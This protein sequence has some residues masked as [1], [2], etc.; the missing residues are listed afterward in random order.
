MYYSGVERCKIII[1]YWDGDFM[2]RCLN[3]L[4][5][6][7]VMTVAMMGMAFAQ[8]DDDSKGQNAEK[9][10]LYKDHIYWIDQ[11]TEK[12]YVSKV[13]ESEM[14]VFADV[15]RCDGKMA[16]KDGYIYYYSFSR[17]AIVK[18]A[19]VGK[20]ESEIRFDGELIEDF[21]ISDEKVYFL[22][23]TYIEDEDREE[24]YICSMGLNGEGMKRLTKGNSRDLTLSKGVIYFSDKD[25]CG[26]IY[27]YDIADGTV[28]KISEEC[29]DKI[30]ID[31]GKLY[32]SNEKGLSVMNI[33]GSECNFLLKGGYYE[34][35]KVFKENI[36]AI[37]SYEIERI[38]S[39]G[40][41]S[42]YM[43]EDGQI[44]GAVFDDSQIYVVNSNDVEETDILNPK[45][46][47]ILN[48]DS[49]L[50]A[51][52]MENGK[53]Y[54]EDGMIL[55]SYDVAL[56]RESI[57]DVDVDYIWG[58]SGEYIYYSSE[59]SKNVKNKRANLET[60]ETED[61]QAMCEY[62]RCIATDEAGIYYFEYDYSKQDDTSGFNEDMNLVFIGN[63]TLEKEE[64]YQNFNVYDG[65]KGIK[66]KDWIFYQGSGGILR[67][68]TKT[69]KVLK[70]GIDD[71]ITA[72]A[73]E[74]IYT[75]DQYSYS[76]RSTDVNGKDMKIEMEGV[77]AIPFFNGKY[78][79]GH[80]D[81]RSEMILIDVGDYSR[82]KLDFQTEYID[83]I[84]YENMDVIY[85][86]NNDDELIKMNTSDFS[87]ESITYGE[88]R[89]G[90]DPYNKQ[91]IIIN[92]YKKTNSIKSFDALKSY[93]EPGTGRNEIGHIIKL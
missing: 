58:I 54:Y 57:L 84:P 60:G 90:A 30:Y 17:T 66:Y 69:N 77:Y 52:Y 29:A 51:A 23:E 55:K 22:N 36:Y 70:I 9:V 93:L 81:S 11:D 35:V 48:V 85:F 6:A 79:F 47:E 10:K 83:F 38:D 32:F 50:N 72:I 65:L 89:H 18:L 26:G 64:L 76:I 20:N 24:I 53:I 1:F 13:G 28:T 67:I 86:K 40:S 78:F 91:A 21:S 16:I 62:P 25:D 87:M 37:D 88:T 59:Q 46:G 12:I 42:I 31:N 63:E 80:D 74:R 75:Y 73:K 71:E 41:K 39:K 34:D 82:R 5:L 15:T 92:R 49:D 56:K 3:V 14:H 2:K 43:K 8:E 45:S 68:D 61:V 44:E 7:F 33:D 4:L 27:S 19:I